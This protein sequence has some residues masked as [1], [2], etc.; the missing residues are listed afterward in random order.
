MKWFYYKITP[1]IE[2]EDAAEI[3]KDI[4]KKIL[5]KKTDDM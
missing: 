5:E 1:D 2:E 3:V 4:A